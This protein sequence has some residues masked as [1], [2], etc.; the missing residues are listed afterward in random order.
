V[1]FLKIKFI[2]ADATIC[3][4]NL[5]KAFFLKKNHLGTPVIK[6]EIFLVKNHLK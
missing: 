2:I 3:I 1:P 5:D 4:S 6:L